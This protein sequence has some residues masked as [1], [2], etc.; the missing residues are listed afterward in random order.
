MKHRQGEYARGNAI[1]NTVKGFLSLLKRGLIDSF[2]HVGEQNP[3]RYVNEFDFRYNFRS[4]LGVTDV[5]G[6]DY[7]LKGIGGKRLNYRYTSPD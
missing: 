6:V 3:Q 7:A 4:A 1:T 2:H 5:E